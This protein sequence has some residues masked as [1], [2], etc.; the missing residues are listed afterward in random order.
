MIISCEFA[1]SWINR[2]KVIELF[3][4]L[5]PLIKLPNRK[6][7]SDNILYKAVTDLNN[8]MVEKLINDRIGITLSF[9]S[10]S[11]SVNKN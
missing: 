7:L 10:R 1:L 9:D 11:M 6:I 3:K 2:S 4:F 5:N 8:T